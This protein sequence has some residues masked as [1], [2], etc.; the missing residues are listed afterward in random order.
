MDVIFPFGEGRTDEVVFDSVCNAFSVEGSFREF[1]TVGGKSNFRN[2]ITMTVQ[3][4]VLPNREVG[5]L[6]FRDF[7]HGEEHGH[8]ASSFQH[9]VRDLLS[10]WALE[11][12]TQQHPE[13]SNI[14][15]WDQPASDEIPGLKLILH[16]ADNSALSMNLR[17]QTTDGYILAVGL[18][19][20]VLERFARTG[21]VNS[22]VAKL[23]TLIQE[24]IP[25][26]ITDQDIQ[27]DEDKD[28]LAAY[29]CATRFWVVHRTEVQALL[30][31][32]ILD[33]ATTHAEE[34]MRRV[35]QSW[36]VAIQEMIS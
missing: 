7:D 1:V 8:V 24:S 3:S 21:R 15:I 16:L 27:F 25:K 32:I 2:Q 29:L 17:N 18:Q 33:R 26:V 6:V 23:Q 10:D 31:Q 30:A 11:P 36:R 35:F 9:I 22:N 4:E 5:I 20:Q 19:E 12:E 14:Y 28:Y 13:E 34:S